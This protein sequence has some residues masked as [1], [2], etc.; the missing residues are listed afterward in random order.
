MHLKI[1]ADGGSRGNPGSAG[2]GVVIR[3]DDGKIVFAGGF[4]LG[5]QTN[6]VAEYTGLLK[7]LQLARQLE[8]TELDI[9]L[10]SEL[11]VRQIN[12]IYKVKNAALKEYY[13]K[14]VNL[15]NQFKQVKVHHIY[16]EDNSMADAMA[17]E[18]MDARGDTGGFKEIQAGDIAENTAKAI[19]AQADLLAALAEN[20]EDIWCKTLTDIDG[21]KTEAIFLEKNKELRI[22][23]QAEKVFITIMRGQ[24]QIA[25]D[26]QQ[27]KVKVGNWLQLSKPTMIKF[28]ADDQQQLIAIITRI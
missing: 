18:A 26:G 8:A 19:V 15:I 9:Y 7:G 16:R 6:N 1:N 28:A 12:G 22:K 3:Q 11:I 17:N 10:D 13:Q 25:A 14:V 21:V 24:G 2:A 23:N 27:T 20:S 4:Y 5:S